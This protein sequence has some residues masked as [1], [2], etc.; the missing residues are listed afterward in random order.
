MS[1]VMEW[2]R[3]ANR[4]RESEE[5]AFLR[6]AVGVAVLAA[7]TA[8][9]REGVGG[10]LLVAAVVVGLPAAFAFSAATRHRSGMVL[11]AGLAVGVVV[12]FV[13]FVR[14]LLGDP[15]NLGTVQAPLAQL[16]LWVQLLHAFDVPARRD[17][18]FS[19]AS[20]LV[21]MAM[22]AVFSTSMGLGLHI[23]VWFPATVA[24]L[25]LAYRSRIG[26]SGSLRLTPGAPPKLTSAR[27]PAMVACALSLAA[28][29]V[30][31]MLVPQAG[32]H[33]GLSFP[34][35]LPENLPVPTLGG[36]S[37]P[38][39]GNSGTSAGDGDAGSG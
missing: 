8:V 37:D 32:A 16:F 4:R 21:L 3:H 30:V 29:A 36:M 39:S 28:G 35:R 12:A 22:A 13:S 20:S 17:L 23:A 27:R 14:H 26:G 5:C 31:F 38:G 33:R 2:V 25:V 1:A 10:P 19:L 15:G 34:S 9:L 7:A 24:A 6:V 11:K 18:M